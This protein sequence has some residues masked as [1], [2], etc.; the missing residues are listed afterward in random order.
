MQA[1]DAVSEGSLITDADKRIIYA[2]A[3][4]RTIT[5]YSEEELLGKNCNMLQGPETDVDTIQLMR[6]SFAAGITFQGD[7]LNYRKD[8]APFWNSL[9][10]TPLKDE[11]GE[12]TH[13]V[14]VQRDISPMM[15]LQEQLLYQATH[16]AVTG[17]PNRVALRDQL[18]DAL[19]RGQRRGTVV[20]VGMVDLDDFKGINDTYGH[21]VGDEVLR[22]VSRRFTGCIRDDDFLARLGGDEFIVVFEGLHSDQPVE[23]LQTALMRLED[24]LAEPIELADGVTLQIG[25]SMGIA[26]SPGHALDA[27][28]LVRVA[29]DALYSVKAKKSTRQSW[30]EV[31]GE[32][33]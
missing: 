24:V 2:N 23:G 15:D 8:G 21:L 13:F 4:I 27:T 9:T 29:D 10:I 12:V 19:A 28:T 20:A 22:A 14:S 1:L 5:G 33:F 16:D 26:F 30:W 17:L 3:A 18:Y 7:I 6:D 11:S 32:S 25:M 31:A